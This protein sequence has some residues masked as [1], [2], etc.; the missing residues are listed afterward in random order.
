M[1][2]DNEKSS[3]VTIDN[4]PKKINAAAIQIVVFMIAIAAIVLAIVQFVA[5]N[6]ERISHLNANQVK[7]GTIR[8]SKEIDNLISDR[9]ANIK[10]LSAFYSSSLT[11]PEVDVE[12]LRKMTGDSNFDFME[13]ADANGLDHNITGGTSDATDRKYYLDG[14]AGNTGLELIF[15]SRATHETLL[16]FYT[17]VIFE[18]KPVGVMIGVIQATGEIAELIDVSYY[19]E[20]AEVYLCDEYG[21]IIASNI[22]LEELDTRK[23][24]S[25]TDV[26][27]NAET[28]DTIKSTLSNGTT[29]VFETG[30][31]ENSIGCVTKL[32]ECEWYLIEV[33]P[34]AAHN[35]LVNSSISIS[36]RLQ[37][38]LLVVFFMVIFAI[39][40]TNII[41]RRNIIEK[42]TKQK[43]SLQ[44]HLNIIQSMGQIYFASYYIDPKQNS[45][46]E[47]LGKQNDHEATEAAGDARNHIKYVIERLIQPEYADV[48][49]EF[50]SL[51]TIDERLKEKQ[52]ITCEFKGVTTG[53]SQAYIIAGDRDNYGKL[54]HVFFAFRK[55]H[56]EKEKEE[57][58]QTKI[59]EQMHAL[60][61]A[62]SR[63]EEQLEVIEG[64]G[65]EYFSIL[66][67]DSINDT[68][69]PYRTE[70][71]EGN[72]I[73][74][75]F[76]RG[77][78]NWSALIQVYADSLVLEEDRSEFME[79]LSFKTKKDF[80]FNYRMIK[81][82]GTSWLQVRVA[83]VKR[84][85]GTNIAVIGTK[86]VD[87]L[88]REEQKKQKALADA[89][90]AAEK[91]NKAKSNFLFNMSHDIRTPMNAI[92]GYTDLL[93]KGVD[94][95]KLR[96]RYIENIQTS[97][98]YLLDLIN[99]V[100]DTARIE[101]GKATLDEEPSDSYRI[102][103]DLDT[104]FA[105]E[106]EKKHL[107]YTVHNSF[108][109]RYVYRDETKVEQILFNV[110]SNAVKYTPEGGSIDI[111]FSETPSEREGW[112]NF[113]STVKDTG[114]G[115]SKE[116]LPHIF[117]SFSREKTVT[118]SKV[119]GTGLGMGI[120]K[121]LVDLMG[122]TISVESELG[123]GTTVSFTVPHRVA[124]APAETEHTNTV[125]DSKTFAGKRILLAEDNELNAEIAA[126]I[127]GETG[128]EVEHAEDG[129][130]CV[131]MLNKHEAGYY[132]LVLMDVQM[133]NMNGIKATTVIRQLPDKAKAE[134]PIIAMTA[135]AF[136]EDRKKCLEAG[137][138]GFVSKPID[139]IKLME[140]LADIL[141]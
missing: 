103:K 133:P 88:V 73:S 6:S 20:R 35:D 131:D 96:N 114:I 94:D 13:F 84:K 100:L 61:Q 138:N 110:V 123:K 9:L 15:E 89:L 60:E 21:D 46:I 74:E 134:T 107:K 90:D 11:S 45:F 10:I 122:G 115:I 91:A 129:I 105:G 4:K 127:L 51:D 5:G 78:R 130:I 22:P 55:I 111:Y 80:S 92:I 118:D 93:K 42:E 97:N 58:A 64:L 28:I 3:G 43:N 99:N 44:R 16:M 8:L 135:N 106:I 12:L 112:T 63:M 136:E 104:A 77:G 68:V 67:V 39:V 126:E 76:N 37:I 87:E 49:R 31:K 79:C 86:N 40:I 71:E 66:L 1:Y 75:F 108:T 119:V 38:I 14:M 128:F 69:I 121:R 132:D 82:T 25:I 85:D 117:D 41:E 23:Q 109:H 137:M 47:L 98:G 113:T 125:V 140:T 26:L 19:D 36:T 124:E 53:W 29:N 54:K 34:D 81:A 141:K 101:S 50:L 72:I 139:I 102:G 17:P 52:V 7:D 27:T 30:K 95:P 120:V 33:F 59:D 116:F 83:Y 18:D 32:D 48:M 24:I 57:A 2:A 62:N 65:T 56:D 70:G